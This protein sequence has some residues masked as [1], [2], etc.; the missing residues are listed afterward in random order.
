WGWRQTPPKPEE[1][2]EQYRR[3]LGKIT[4][5]TSIP[6]LKAFL[7]AGGAIVT[8]GS[9][10]NLA[11][12][13]GLPVSNALVENEKPLPGTRYFIPGSILQVAFDS[14]LSAAWGMPA[15]GDVNFDNSPVFKLGSD[16]AEKGIKPIAWF[17][18]DKPLRSGWAWGQSYLKDGV[19]AFAAPV[20]K[21]T[22]YAYGPEITF[23]AQ[24]HGTFK[25][26]F[27]DLYNL[28]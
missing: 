3:M 4:K 16:A 20:G 21:G 27:N 13:L 23:R 6:K 8:I 25:L 2:P 22:L 7:E 5:D 15:V 11:Y 14:T 19:A 9:S 28:K 17:T 24:S 18:T 10:T 12:H 26:L 1:I